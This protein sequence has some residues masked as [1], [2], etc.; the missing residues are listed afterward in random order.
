MRAIIA[1]AVLCVVPASARADS[2]VGLVGGLAIPVS[3]DQY[4]DT[5]DTS[6]VL[7]ARVGAYPHE[8]GGFFSFEWMIAD[9]KNDGAL[10]LDFDAHRFR[11]IVG[12]ELH[13]AV[14]NT[15]AVTA[16][17]GLGLD[18]ARATASGNIGPIAVDESE[19]D[20]GLGFEFAGGLWAHL[21]GLEVGGE[22]S[23]PISMHD[24]D[25]NENDY[26]FDYTSVDLQ[27][28]FGVRFV[29]H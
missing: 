11:L 8:L 14:S 7:G 10:G 15:L 4:T 24:D 2:Y 18:I 28:L 22:V 6:P 1:L 25:A 5:V 16:R 20:L 29:S 3:D 12:P 21:G 23:L 26:D 27:L 13:H 17:G 9:V 19:T